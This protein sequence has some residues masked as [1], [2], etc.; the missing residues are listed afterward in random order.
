MRHL[1]LR[2]R[3]GFL[4]VLANDAPKLMGLTATLVMWTSLPPENLPR[5][6]FTCIR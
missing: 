3:A 4:R 6:T 2:S 5:F 1:K